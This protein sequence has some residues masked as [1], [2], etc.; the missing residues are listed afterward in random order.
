MTR[1]PGLAKGGC[2]TA[3]AKRNT[4]NPDTGALCQIYKINKKM[5]P[6]GGHPQRKHPV[7]CILHHIFCFII[8]LLLHPLHLDDCLDYLVLVVQA[9]IHALDDILKIKGMGY[10]FLKR[11]KPLADSADG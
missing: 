3:G 1:R 9:V 10:D 11:D 8:P 5:L 4:A 2:G 7:I 6:P